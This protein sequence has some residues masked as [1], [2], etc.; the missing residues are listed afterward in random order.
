[1]EQA[2]EVI[3]EVKEYWGTCQTCGNDF[4]LSFQRESP[5]ECYGCRRKREKEEYEKAVQFMYGARI[6]EMVVSDEDLSS[7]VVETNDGRRIEFIAGGYDER[8]IEW[9]DVEPE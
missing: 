8:D 3:R 1:M 5:S 9:G 4:R 7:I 6:V 2:R